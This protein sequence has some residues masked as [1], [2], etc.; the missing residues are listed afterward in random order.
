VPT[1]VKQ[2]VVM[3]MNDPEASIEMMANWFRSGE[4]Q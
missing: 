1:P 4:H 3:R 2:G